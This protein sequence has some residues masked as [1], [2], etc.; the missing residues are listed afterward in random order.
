MEKDNAILIWKYLDG[1]CNAEEKQAFQKLLGEN[2]AFAEEFSA[3]QTL[4]NDL[5]HMEVEEPSMRFSV[6][7][8]EQTPNLYRVVQ[9]S[10][11]LLPKGLV[12]IF[13]TLVGSA[14][15]LSL[16]L[17]FASHQAVSASLNILNFY[18]LNLGVFSNPLVFSAFLG[19][20]AV[21]SYFLMDFT[22]KKW[23]LKK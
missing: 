6:R 20:L 17:F 11:D 16:G 23:F 1:E 8:V 14:A 21:L 7:V 3:A 13:S 12:R 18:T 19:S 9:T 10:A 2:L 5:Q 4:H 15:L 22:L